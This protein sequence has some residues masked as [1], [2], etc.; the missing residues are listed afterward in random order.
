MTTPAIT[1]IVPAAGAGRRAQHDAHDLPKQYRE[2]KGEPMLRLAVRALLVDARV[3]QVRVAVAPH[4]QRAEA[5][6]AG[7][8]RTLWRPCGKDTRAQTVLAALKDA[9][10]VDDAW[11][12]VH[13]AARPGLPP[14]ALARLLDTCLA[15][16][17]GGLLA[18]PVSDTVKRA[19]NAIEIPNVSKPAAAAPACVATT[20]P[21]QDLW[22]AQTPQLFPAGALQR[23]LQ[24]ALDAGVVPGDEAGAMEMQGET[25]LLIP[26][27]P[28]NGKVT[29]PEDFAWMQTWL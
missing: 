27:S 3:T 19:K 8:P 16:G 11:V 1:A 23:A 28:R 10:L 20:V 6:L 22:L 25:P 24:A 15:Q 26:G 5:A 2:I 9:A 21:R 18:L 29:W 4:D 7:L 17:R 13:D 12:L 14:A